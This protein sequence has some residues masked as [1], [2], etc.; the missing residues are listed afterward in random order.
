MIIIIMIILSQALL[1]QFDANED[2]QE[3]DDVNERNNYGTEG[4]FRN[5]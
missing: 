4:G 2:N 1:L 5:G 3:E